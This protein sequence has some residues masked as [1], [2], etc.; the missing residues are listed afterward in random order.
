MCA[1]YLVVCEI[2]QVLPIFHLIMHVSLHF[3]SFCSFFILSQVFI[4]R[5]ELH[6][7]PCPSRSSSVG[8]SLDV[9]PSLAQALTLLSAHPEACQ[10]SP[11]ICS[12][13]KKQLQGW[14]FTQSQLSLSLYSN[15]VKN[16]SGRRFVHGCWR[17]KW[18]RITFIYSQG[19]ILALWIVNMKKNIYGVHFGTF[20]RINED[21][22]F[23]LCVS[24]RYPE[25]IKSNLHRAHCY[26]PAGIASVLA[27]RPDL[28]APAVS[29]FYLRDPVQLQA[30]RSFRTFP[31][32][33][34]VLTLVNTCKYVRFI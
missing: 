13:L 6:I 22:C 23:H 19:V 11:K 5:G 25:K 28:V 20:L 8:F 27:Q 33:T 17:C 9:V 26:I 10:A 15:R 34:R 32:D 14:G 4:Y 2:K 1:T 18:K 16:K 24:C 3:F 12:A 29:A 30:C 21:S 7:L 31:P